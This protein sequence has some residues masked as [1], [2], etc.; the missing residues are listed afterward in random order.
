[1]IAYMAV[2]TVEILGVRIHCMNTARIMEFL[3]T[4]AGTTEQR[5]I[6]Y[7]NAHCLNVA[8][9][10]A[11]YRTVLNDAD[12]VYPDGVSVAWAGRWVGGCQMQKATGA[13]W[14]EPFCRLAV[15]QG[16]RIYILAGRPGVAA[17]ARGKL[18]GRY[19][20]LQVVGTSDGYFVERSEPEVL[21]DIA[22]VKPDV[23][24]VGLGTPRQEK[25]L[26][27][28]REELPVAIY[29]AVGALFDYVAGVERR[30]PAWMRAL[31]L[32][33]A[34][35]LLIDPVGKWHRYLLGNPLFVLRVLQQWLRRGRRA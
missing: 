22:A 5:T 25:W 21:Q 1:M 27:A 29:W 33:W 24:F 6:M 4:W 11:A 20:R 23:V 30:A 18:T 31:A 34:W 8:H 19:P 3:R 10:D 14:I 9:E 2:E 15:E 28:H 16:W 7:V 35:R 26:A 32:E 17:A 13:D 12:L